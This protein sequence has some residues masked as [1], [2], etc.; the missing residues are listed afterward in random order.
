M[1]L[2]AEHGG[3]HEE[4]GIVENLAFSPNTCWSRCNAP[5]VP[6]T[7]NFILRLVETRTEQEEIYNKSYGR[8]LATQVFALKSNRFL[9]FVWGNSLCLRTTQHSEWG[10]DDLSP[11]LTTSK[12]GQ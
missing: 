7:Q 12:E 5:P 4:G 9:D 1:D 11:Y 10:P 8:T 6:E 2:E 3:Y